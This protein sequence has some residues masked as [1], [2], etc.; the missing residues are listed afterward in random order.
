MKPTLKLFCD[1]NALEE[2]PV[3]NVDYLS[4]VWR[5]EDIWATRREK[6]SDITWLYGPWKS[7]ESSAKA[8]AAAA[9]ISCE[10]SRLRSAIRPALKRT[11]QLF[12]ASCTQ[13]GPECPTNG[14]LVL[15]KDV[16]KTGGAWARFRLSCPQYPLSRLAASAVRYTMEWSR[17]IWP[18]FPPPNR[19]TVH[20][21]IEVRQCIAIGSTITHDEA[22]GESSLFQNSV[23]GCESF[24]DVSR[25]TG[26]YYFFMDSGLF[27][28]KSQGQTITELPSTELKSPHGLIEENDGFFL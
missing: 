25:P 24:D 3:I 18:Q 20:F 12:F 13:L 10:C 27:Y 23:G 1:D 26:E 17:S 21:D 5:E 7:I 9:Q 14:P 8:H 4:N 15:E 22:Y 28:E 6:D 19:P 2:E 16:L 11:T